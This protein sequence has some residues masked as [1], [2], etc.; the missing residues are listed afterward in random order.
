MTEDYLSQPPFCPYCEIFSVF[1]PSS[2]FIYGRDFGPVWVCDNYPT[3]DSYVGCHPGTS[4]PLGR[5]ADRKL[6]E[7]KKRAHAAF[8][9]LWRAKMTFG[10]SKKTARTAA[11][12]WLASQLGISVNECHIGHFD[13]ANCDR[14]VE[15]CAP[16]LSRIQLKSRYAAEP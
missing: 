3:C 14:V 15:I 8:D 6:R 11:Y 10:V 5:L 9:Q 16:Y 7:A 13:K 12:N 2:D 1:E 4:E